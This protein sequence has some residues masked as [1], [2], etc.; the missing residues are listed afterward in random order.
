MK[1]Q[2]V[3]AGLT[4]LAVA[5]TACAGA[6]T[7]EDKVAV[8]AG[9][10]SASNDRDWETAA[11]FLA[12]DVV[13]ETPTGTSRGLDEWWAGVDSGAPGPDRQEPIN[14]TVSEDVVRVEAIVTF[15][16]LKFP[17]ILEVLVSDGKIQHFSVHEP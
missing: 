4:V 8:V 7:D 11:S 3:F 5:L 14:F 15:S 10:L 9:W 13:F 17:A 6:E 1:T 16:D 12:E 2:R